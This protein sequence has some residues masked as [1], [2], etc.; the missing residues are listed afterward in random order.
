MNKKTWLAIYIII[1][2]L[3]IVSPAFYVIVFVPA[4]SSIALAIMLFLTGCLSIFAGIRQ[5]E[6]LTRAE[7]SSVWW[8]NY[9][10]MLGMAQVSWSVLIFVV[11]E[12]V[13]NHVNGTILTIIGIPAL[14]LSLGFGI[15]A[16][17]LLMIYRDEREKR[18]IG[19]L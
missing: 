14:I 11:S 10:I 8:K 16:M 9:S 17:V 15:Y 6:V 2:V 13:R 18:T 1:T 19:I 7:S 5:R 3:I 12:N 4:Y